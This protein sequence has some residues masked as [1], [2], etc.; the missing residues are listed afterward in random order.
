MAAVQWC[1]AVYYDPGTD[2]G[3]DC[4][5]PEGHEGGHMAA[6][7]LTVPELAPERTHKDRQRALAIDALVTAVLYEGANPAYHRETMARHRKEWPVLWSA[8]DAVIAS[9]A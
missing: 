5:L 4:V 2:E 7:D 3:V 1:S 9:H 6:V 8:I